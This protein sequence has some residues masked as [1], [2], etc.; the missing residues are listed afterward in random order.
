MT[1]VVTGGFPPRSRLWWWRRRRR[2]RRCCYHLAYVFCSGEYLNAW[3][4]RDLKSFYINDGDGAVATFSDD[5]FARRSDFCGRLSEWIS[6]GPLVA[7]RCVGRSVVR[8]CEE[9]LSVC[10]CG[11]RHWTKQCGERVCVA[12]VMDGFQ[13]EA[14]TACSTACLL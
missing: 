12:Y 13:W 2:E 1:L 7:L 9:K 6:G 3:R 14:S 8:E 4:G 11:G 5:A 10:K